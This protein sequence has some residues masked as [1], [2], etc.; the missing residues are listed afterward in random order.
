MNKII[1]GQKLYD[2][3]IQK[4][5][6]DNDFK[7]LLIKDPETAIEK[8][9]GTNLNIPVGRKIVVEDQSDNSKIYI[10]IPRNMTMD[11]LELSSEELEMVSGGTSPTTSTWGCA[12]GIVTGVVQI[13]DWVVDGWN[14]KE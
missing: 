2:T 9:M 8:V 12:V 14:N 7:D 1:K 10:N 11:D 13:V 6:S 3:L 4:S 5:F